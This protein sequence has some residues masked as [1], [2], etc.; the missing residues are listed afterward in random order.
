MVQDQ[1]A[2]IATRDRVTLVAGLRLLGQPKGR[3]VALAFSPSGSLLGTY[4]KEHLVPR[5]ELPRLEPGTDLVVVDAPVRYGIEICKDM[6][7]P[8]PASRYG[9]ADIAL[10]LVLA[11]DFRVDGWLHSRMA[12]VR[13]VEQGLPLVRSAREGLLSVSDAYG[14]VLAQAESGDIPA[15]LM[16]LTP[17]GHHATPYGR[18]GDWLP[19]LSL[20]LW[21]ALTIRLVQLAVQRRAGH[22]LPRAE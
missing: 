6:D 16:A 9:Q 19:H 7:F 18:Y 20:A 13:A 3:N 2:E 10:L 4:V 5:R 17:V 8:S 15:D 22:G 11:W 1:L 21:I 12:L 14:R